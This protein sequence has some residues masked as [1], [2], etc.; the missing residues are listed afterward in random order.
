MFGIPLKNQAST[1]L[2]L[3]K[4]KYL[5]ILI[6]FKNNNMQLHISYNTREGNPMVIYTLGGYLTILGFK[7]HWTAI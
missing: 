6:I 7:L 5:K 3:L 1:F 4:S 2:I